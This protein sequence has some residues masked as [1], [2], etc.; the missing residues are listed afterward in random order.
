MVKAE[1]VFQFVLYG[2]EIFVLPHHGVGVDGYLL[3]VLR[4]HDH[5]LYDVDA[6][7]GLVLEY[8]QGQCDDFLSMGGIDVAGGKLPLPH[9]LDSLV[10][11]GVDAE[12]MDVFLPAQFLCGLVGPERGQV[13]LAEHHVEGLPFL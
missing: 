2:D 7:V 9:G 3:H 1:I 10:G 13:A 5:A 8:S 12:K 11:Q 6:F 4:C